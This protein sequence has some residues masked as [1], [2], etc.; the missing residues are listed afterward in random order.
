MKT[1][2]KSKKTKDAAVT[3]IGEHDENSWVHGG[4]M[5]YQGKTWDVWQG[6]IKRSA[7]LPTSESGDNIHPLKWVETITITATRTL[8]KLEVTEGGDAK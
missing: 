6:I 5:E 7:K 4:T 3:Y 2:K 8:S 1:P